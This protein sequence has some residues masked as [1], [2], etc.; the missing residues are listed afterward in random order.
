MGSRRHQHCTGCLDTCSASE[1][2]LK[3][4]PALE[5]KVADIFDAERWRIVSFQRPNHYNF[6]FMDK[7]PGA[8]CCSSVTIVSILR[9][10]T[11]Y[12][13]AKSTNMSW[14][15]RAFGYWSCIEMDVGII[16]ACM[17]ALYSLFKHLF[18]QAFA[19]S[20][21]TRGSGKGIL[22]KSSGITA[23]ETPAERRNQD[24]KDFLPLVDIENVRDNRPGI[25]L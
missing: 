14:D 23:G 7:L 19:G 3:T 1:A 4:Q 10:E 13:F 17:P 21:H 22:S 18:P 6:K 25:A 2:Y 11:L 20:M 24:T 5:E 8:N 9:L 16:C 15:G 12:Q